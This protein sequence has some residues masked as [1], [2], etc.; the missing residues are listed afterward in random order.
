MND[1]VAG[2]KRACVI[3]PAYREEG[4][5]GR[6]VRAVAAHCA[7]VVVVDDGSDDATAA[8][9]REAGAHVL[10][11]EQNRGKG[12]ALE[13]AFAYARREGCEYVITM[14]GDGQHDAADIGRFVDAYERGTAPVL[15][16]NRMSDPGTMPW[17]RRWTNRFMSGLLSRQ[18]GQSVPDTQCGF[19]L[20][21]CDVLPARPM[22]S[23]R[24]ATESEMLLD[25]AAAGVRVG[26]VPIRV[27]Y[28]DEKSKINPI[29]DTVRFFRMLWLHRHGRRASAQQDETT[30]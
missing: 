3:V 17:L 22:A 13:T 23:H 8:E 19:R 5:I 27:I 25:L 14:D 11:H 16:G 15:V 20:L 12:K 7:N 6:T 28:R 2:S 24:F 26:S 10:V 21:R 30:R 4:R 18:M 9:A 29:V 1:A